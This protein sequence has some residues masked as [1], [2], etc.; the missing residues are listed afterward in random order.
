MTSGSITG[1]ERNW[2]Y[3]G[4][5]FKDG[6]IVDIKCNMPVNLEL[7]KDRES[8]ELIWIASGVDYN[9]TSSQIMKHSYT[10]YWCEVDFDDLANI[11]VSRFF[12]WTE[13]YET[14]W[15]EAERISDSNFALLFENNVKQY[16]TKT[17]IEEIQKE[18][19]SKYELVEISQ[20]EEDFYEFDRAYVRETFNKDALYKLLRM[21]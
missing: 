4:F 15:G 5:S 7:Y 18:L 19:F 6:T 21:Y 1:G 13:E 10:Y 9:F 8:G 3:H 11:S 20:I 17:E 14:K 12:Y 16:T 2:I